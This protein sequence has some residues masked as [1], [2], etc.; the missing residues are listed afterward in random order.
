MDRRGPPDRR[1]VGPAAE[2]AGAAAR[3]IRRRPN[4]QTGHH[5]A[6]DRPASSRTRRGDGGRSQRRQHATTCRVPTRATTMN[7]LGRAGTNRPQ[8][9]R[10][11]VRRLTSRRSM[12]TPKLVESFYARI[13]NAGDLT[14]VPDLLHRDFH[15]RGSL[16]ADLRG[17]EAFKGYVRAV[18]HALADYRCEIL[19]CVAEGNL[20]SAKMKFSGRHV[21]SFEAFLPRAKQYSGWP[22]HGSALTATLLQICGSS[23]TSPC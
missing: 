2:T 10:S 15:F 14:A 1:M 7:R 18:R 23:V 17:H 20:A 13:W 16:G 3:C 5:H 6:P 4:G 22:R 11:V 9:R 19:A 8:L 12:S 21:A